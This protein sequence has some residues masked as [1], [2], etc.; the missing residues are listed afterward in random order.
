MPWVLGDGVGPVASSRDREWIV[1][2]REGSPLVLAVISS[3]LV[4][5][6]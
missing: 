5:A 4:S 2:D 3:H 6:N 1:R